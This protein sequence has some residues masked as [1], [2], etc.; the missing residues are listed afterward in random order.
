VAVR[1]TVYVAGWRDRPPSACSNSFRM[2]TYGCIKD[3][4]VVGKTDIE[5]FVIRESNVAQTALYN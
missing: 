2:I 3:S 1:K 4:T 5:T